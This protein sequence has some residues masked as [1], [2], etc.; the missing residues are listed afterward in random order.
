MRHRLAKPFVF[1]CCLSPLIWLAAIGPDGWGANPVETFNRFLGDW[2]LRFILL[3]LCV[4]PLATLSHKAALLRFRR[5]IGL[6]AFFYACLHLSSYVVF[7]QF[8]DV[9]A[10]WRDIV[11]RNFITVGMISFVALIP[12]AVTSTNKSMRRMGARNWQKL[13]RMVYAIGI[14]AVAHNIM[15][16]KANYDE[17]IIHAIILALLL[18]W[19]VATRRSRSAKKPANPKI[20]A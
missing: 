9:A 3:T 16:V 1:L 8:F 7:D 15:M 11:K 2:A 19:R 12:L 4:S 5:M 17:A 20:A 6:F 13:H 10:I 14:G 18:G